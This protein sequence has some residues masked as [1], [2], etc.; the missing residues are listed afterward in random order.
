[1]PNVMDRSE[2]L[3]RAAPNALHLWHGMV[4]RV[5][6]Q[7]YFHGDGSERL[8]QTVPNVMGR[9]ERLERTRLDG[10]E[11]KIAK[12]R[13]AAVVLELSRSQSS[14]FDDIFLVFSA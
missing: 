3:E 12:A 8:V 6:R 11:D 2:P 14:T 5:T 13:N 9:S 1:M 10:E 4:R 7:D